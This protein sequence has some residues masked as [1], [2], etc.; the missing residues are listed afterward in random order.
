MPDLPQWLLTRIERVTRQRFK[1]KMQ[2]E[3]FQLERGGV[4]SSLR[5]RGCSEA[6]IGKLLNVSPQYLAQKF[7][8][9]S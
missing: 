4:V 3:K 2:G 6:Q 9:G 5:A 8:R 1:L 7:P